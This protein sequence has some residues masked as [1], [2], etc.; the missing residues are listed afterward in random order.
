MAKNR[1]LGDLSWIL[2]IASLLILAS[3]SSFAA[4]SCS[5]SNSSSCNVES[6]KLTLNQL[7]TDAFISETQNQVCIVY[8]YSNSCS[9]CKAI[10]PFIDQLEQEYAGKTRLTKYDVSDPENIKLYDQLCSLRSY[11]GKSIPLIGINDRILVGES[12]IRNNLRAEIERGIAMDKKICPLGSEQ[13]LAQNETAGNGNSSAEPPIRGLKDLRFMTVLPIIL[14]A[15]L[16]DGVNPCAFII[17]IFIMVF[18]QQISGNKKRILKVTSAY[19]ISFLI[20]N[21][22][23]GVIYYFVSVKIG[24]PEIIRYIVV[25][26][27]IVAGL[28][29][30]KDF[31]WYG[32][33]ISL[34]IPKSA[35]GYLMSLVHLASVPASL[36]LGISV[37]VLEAPCSIPIYLSVIEVL[38]GAGRSLV[39]VMPYILLYN[40]MFIL[41]LVVIAVAAYR[42]YDAKI[43]EEKSLAAKR[44]MKLVIGIILILL[45]LAF[46]LRWF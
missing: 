15:G 14:V 24:F 22:L 33:G 16:S 4:E 26:V 3:A 21:I 12:E 41:P 29:N 1:S 23:I 7:E 43:F 32:K 2:I 8:F 11:N 17:L 45:A 6:G 39:A 18:L 13:C 5:I 34:G 10:K 40:L 31:F 35:K 38:K 19:I 42:G 9:H 36:V 37:A 20:T 28:I 46:I 30:I 27:S 25:A 44:Y